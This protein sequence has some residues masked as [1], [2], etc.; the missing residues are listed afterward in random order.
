MMGD[1]RVSWAIGTAD[2]SALGAG[3][4]GRIEEGTAAVAVS[5]HALDGLLQDEVLLRRS[6]GFGDLQAVLL[7]LLGNDVDRGIFVLIDLLRERCFGAGV[8]SWDLAGLSYCGWLCCILGRRSTGC[9]CCGTVRRL[10]Y[11][12]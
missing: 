4:G 1:I 5:P 7:G 11:L 12:I 9:C 10:V 6:G 2:V 3:L 8:T